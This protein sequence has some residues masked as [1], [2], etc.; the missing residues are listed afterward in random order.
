MSVA[1]E[2]R[3]AWRAD[4]TKPLA[5]STRRDAKLRLSVLATLGGRCEVC[6]AS[7]WRL[8]QLDHREGEARARRTNLHWRQELRM[9]RNMGREAL[10]AMYR[11]LCVTCHYLETHPPHPEV[12]ELA[13][14]FF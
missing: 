8:L 3:H 5:G 4:P 12:A 2:R 11:V 7:D 10:V 13:L 1:G 14:E 9:L 6:G